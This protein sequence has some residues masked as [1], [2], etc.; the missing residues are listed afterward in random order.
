MDLKMFRTGFSPAG[1]QN[2]FQ[3]E[4]FRSFVF[5][6]TDRY[7]WS[8]RCIPDTVLGGWGILIFVFQVV[9][10]GIWTVFAILLHVHQG[11]EAVIF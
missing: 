11:E 6:F 9:P 4:E 7:L 2:G 8:A 5:L 10:T 3:H 1:L